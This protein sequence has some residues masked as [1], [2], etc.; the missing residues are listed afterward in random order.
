MADGY[1]RTSGAPGVCLVIT[2]PGLTN[3]ATA[4]ANAFHDSRP[5]LV[6]SGAG[7]NGQLGGQ[8]ALHDLPDQRQLM[9]SMTAESLLVEDPAELATAFQRAWEVF[10][11]GR[12]RPVHIAVPVN[13]LEAIACRAIRLDS[14]SR[15][16]R[17]PHDAL[18]TA[19]EVLIAAERPVMVLGGGA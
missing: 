17:P 10:E 7:P 19:R 9:S 3:A 14:S 15:P 12:P 18:A 2:G 4:I 1:G 8:G 5:L 13:V 16:P 11:C 6:L